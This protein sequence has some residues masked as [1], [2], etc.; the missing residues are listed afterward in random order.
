MAKLGGIPDYP[1]A[2]IPHPIGSLDEAGLRNR[3]VEALPQVI[4]SLLAR[5]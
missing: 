1:F 5:S 2:L 4:A 3:A